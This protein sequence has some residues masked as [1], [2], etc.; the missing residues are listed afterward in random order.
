M[1][2]IIAIILIQLYL[3]SMLAGI[4]AKEPNKVEYISSKIGKQLKL[5]F[6][7]A[8]RVGDTLYLSGQIGIDPLTGKLVSGGMAAEARQTMTNIQTTLYKN[9]LGFDDVIKCTV[10][11]DDIKK[12]QQFNQIYRQYFKNH[13][14][15][16][17]ALGV[18]GLAL[19]AAIE[20]ECIAY[21]S[22]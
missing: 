9:K 8:V 20:V 11:I 1:K 16:R 15:A 19:G 6:S 10:F 18:N 17:S 21:F 2:K 4:L 14:P 22:K 12:W 13:F 7:E 5:P 3:W